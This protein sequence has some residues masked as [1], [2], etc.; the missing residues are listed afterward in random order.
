MPIHDWTRVMA[1]VFHD[2]HSSWITE[3]KKTL[4]TGLLPGEYYA[5]A[6]QITGSFGP[7]VLTLQEPVHGSLAPVK[8]PSGGIAV[9]DRPPRVEFHARAQI[10][11]YAAKAKSVVIRHLSGHKVVAI[12]EI[13]SPGNKNGQTEFAAFV[14]KADQTLLAGIHLLIVDLFP[15]TKRDPQGLHRAIWGREGD[16]DFAL[17][18]DKRLTCVSYV[19]YPGIEV[20]LQPVSVGV[21]LPDMPLFLTPEIYV[22]VPLEATYREAWQTVPRFWRDALTAVPEDGTKRIRRGRKKKD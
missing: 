5:M 9:A 10:D 6:E 11:L 14:Q 3:I 12:I 17:P 4:N 2:F 13:V 8:M 22:P 1:G 7:D 18:E 20:F 21:P 19:G 15:P 16:G